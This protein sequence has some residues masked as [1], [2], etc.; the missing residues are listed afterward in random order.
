M[1]ETKP[2]PE[3][4]CQ[5]CG[6]K[7]ERKRFRNKQLEPL[8]GFNQRKFCTWKCLRLAYRERPQDFGMKRRGA[9]SSG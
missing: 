4:Y 6:V 5:Q 2:T 7:L 1:N 9:T 8:N 3:R